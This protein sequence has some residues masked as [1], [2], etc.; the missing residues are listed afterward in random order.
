METGG[1]CGYRE[2]IGVLE[3]AS[4][5]HKRKAPVTYWSISNR[6]ASWSDFVF[7]RWQ[8]SIVEERKKNQQLF[9][10]RIISKIPHML[11]IMYSLN[12]PFCFLFKSLKWYLC[13]LSHSLYNPHP[14]GGVGIFLVS[15]CTFILSSFIKMSALNIMSTD[16]TT[17]S[18]LL[19]HLSIDF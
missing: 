15:P 14:G 1:R 16:Y 10:E 18:A 12:I 6:K 13:S 8:C 9:L 7:E 19:L 3:D 2:L 11:N 5:L 4:L 17:L